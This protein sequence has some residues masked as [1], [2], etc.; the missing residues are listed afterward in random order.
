MLAVHEQEPSKIGEPYVFINTVTKVV[1]A[2]DQDEP[3]DSIFADTRMAELVGQVGLRAAERRT[4]VAVHHVLDPYAHQV[5][6]SITRSPAEK[7]YTE[8]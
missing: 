7:P 4:V 8:K 5:T 6:P 2:A 1:P 3:L